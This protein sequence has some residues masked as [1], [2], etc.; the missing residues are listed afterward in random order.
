MKKII[1]L[2]IVLLVTVSIYAQ[3][4]KEIYEW[5]QKGTKASKL[6]NNKEA[7]IYFEKIKNTFEKQ[8]WN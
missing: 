7:I 2:L 6:G 8:N 4:E 5:M 1:V 3:T